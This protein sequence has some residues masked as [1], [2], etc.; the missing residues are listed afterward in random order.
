MH[1]SKT[2][3]LLTCIS[4]TAAAL[5]GAGSAF[6]RPEVPGQ[7][8]DA[9]GMTCVPLCTMC[10]ATNPGVKANWTSMLGGV[11]Y[12]DILAE[13]D[14][15]ATYQNW[16]A[17][18]INKPYADYVK[19][20]YKPDTLLVAGTPPLNVCGPVYG[21]ALP[22]AKQAL[23]ASTGDYAGAMWVAGAVIA[24]AVLRRRKRK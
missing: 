15:T 10:H 16:A 20:G 18:P 24:G 11:L 17:M 7:L 2:I 1:L 12:N 8:H 9:A 3:R 21:C 5:L 13:R 4:A 14:I 19:A 23:G 6:A 22:P